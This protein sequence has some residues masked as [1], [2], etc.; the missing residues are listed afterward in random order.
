MESDKNFSSNSYKKNMKK[1]RN[2]IYGDKS[3]LEDYDYS[4]EDNSI[5]SSSDFD[6]IEDEDI[7]I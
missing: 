1:N 6:I 2:Y 5:I 7:L 4:S 3:A